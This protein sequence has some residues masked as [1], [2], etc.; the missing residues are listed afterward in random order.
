M[1]RIAILGC[2]GSVGCSAL[3]V[4]KQ[5]PQLFEVVALAAGHNIEL[6]KEQIRSFSPKLVS[7]KTLDAWQELKQIFPHIEFVYGDEGVQMVAGFADADVVISAIVGAAG[8]KPTLHAIASGKTIGLA[9]KESMVIAGAIMA[10]LA[11]KTGVAILPIDSEH[12]A[13]FQCLNGEH[14]SD[15]KKI[16]LTA[17]GGPFLHLPQDDFC[18]ITK[19]QALKHPN[20]DMGAK[21]TIDS[22]TMMNKGLEVIEAKWI[23]D[24]PV[25][26]IDVVIH[27]Q[28]IVHSMVEFIDGSVVSQ[29][30]VPD[31]RV[32]IAYALSYPRRISTQVPV[33]NLPQKETLTFFEPN[34]DKF[35]CLQLAF[36]V[37]K[38][39]NS[40]APVLNA[41]NEVAVEKFLTDQI[42][43]VN[44]PLIVEKCLQ[45]H[46]PFA[47]NSLDDVLGAD[48]W[49]REFCKNLY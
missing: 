35:R 24:F 23:F 40:Y 43:F 32:P 36:D 45:N 33:L 25:E 39:N 13:I 49:A 19:A 5:H 28:S 37:A 38:Q 30:G 3:D 2:T 10:K 21:I 48:Q 26:K 29:M 16:I 4:C 9:N 8:L 14:K 27:P 11:Q 6:L 41:A 12:S 46:K 20:W 15:V 47:L 17:S 42:A 1:K 22:A 44:I 34:L 18:K 7:V 31:M